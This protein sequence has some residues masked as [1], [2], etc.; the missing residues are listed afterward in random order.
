MFRVG[1]A[2]VSGEV[3]AAGRV[4]SVVSTEIRCTLERLDPRGQGGAL[5]SG[6]STI[7]SLLPD[8]ATVRAGDVL[9]EMDASYYKELVRR[10]EIVVEQARADHMQAAL[11]LDVS[12]IGVAA[13]REGEQKQ[14]ETEFKGQIALAEA[15]LA[16]QGDRV[17]WVNR[18]VEKGYASLAQ[19][20]SEKQTQERLAFSLQQ[21]ALALE[22]YARFTAPKELLA[23]Q[24]QVI[25]AESTLSFQTIR[26]KREEE[27]LAHYRSLVD[28]CTVRAPHGGYLVH[29]NRPGR[30]P[31][32]YEGAP[33]RERMRLFTLP[34]QSKLEVEVLLHETVV[35][36]VRTGMAAS[37]QLEALPDERLEGNLASIA[38]VPLS[39]QNAES[40]NEAIYFLGHV[41]L[42]A[43]PPKLRPGMTAEVTI[44]TGLRRG[45]LAVP[46]T[47]VR[48]EADHEFC[49]VEHADSVERRA[50]KVSP[51]TE[52]LVEVIEGLDE[53]EEVVLDPALLASTSTK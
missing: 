23:L 35:D 9:C 7:L 52:D 34:D 47:S 46:A 41:H 16:R 43:L 51:A 24:S 30:E 19:L 37:I 8:G 1:R 31:R 29:A 48:V 38:P 3:L 49:Y 42:D 13:Y 17:A 50:V 25:G 20:R 5:T 10:Q 26:L 40:G 53:G 22:N 45:V 32:V 14:V 44:A 2:D 39:D 21:S 6:A 4:A 12:R 33:V 28:R 11:A 15:D 36:R 27:R 18:M